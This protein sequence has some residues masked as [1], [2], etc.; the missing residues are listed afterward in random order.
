MKKGLE[1]RLRKLEVGRPDPALRGKV[2]DAVDAGL[3]D[4]PAPFSWRS[5]VAA[6]RVESLLAG[7][8][9]AT[10]TLLLLLN[11][12]SERWQAPTVR[13]DEA[14]V[15]ALV[16]EL[17]LTPGMESRY[18]TRLAWTAERLAATRRIGDGQRITE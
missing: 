16:E 18:R 10:G 5:W 7:G 4:R 17:D 13:V 14:A 9:V 1:Q 12:S 3:T 2:L 8:I 15:Q 11:G 6:W